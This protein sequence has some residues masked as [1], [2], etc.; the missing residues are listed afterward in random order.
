MD[1]LT[2]IRSPGRL[3]AAKA[4]LLNHFTLS[5][6]GIES[7]FLNFNAPHRAKFSGCVS[8]DLVSR[9]RLKEFYSRFATNRQS[10]VQFP[11]FTFH[12]PPFGFPLTSAILLDRDNRRVSLGQL[13]I[14]KQDNH[15]VQRKFGFSRQFVRGSVRTPEGIPSIL[16]FR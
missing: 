8:T 11:G 15:G 2:L 14:S 9:G 13:Q 10:M 5:D 1:I 3:E 16:H 6:A 7:F 4:R 12:W